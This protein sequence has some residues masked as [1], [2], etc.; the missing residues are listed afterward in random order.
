MAYGRKEIERRLSK[1]VQEQTPDILPQI[2]AARKTERGKVIDMTQALQNQKN[3]NKKKHTIRNLAIGAA[4]ALVLAIGGFAGYQYQFAVDTAVSIDVNP[5]IELEVN[6]QE[7]VLKAN[8]LNEDAK[9]LLDGMELEGTNLKTAV[10]AVIGSMV[11]NGYLTADANS[12]LLTVDNDD[13]ARREALQKELTEGV[14][15]SLKQLSLDGTVF[16]QSLQGNDELKALAAQY[17]ISEGK[18]RWI[19]MLTQADAS[20]KA[21]VLA[22]LSINDLALLAEARNL[23]GDYVGTADETGYIGTEKA[24]E[25]AV[26]KAGGGEV[27]SLEM[28]IDDGRMVYEGELVKDGVE[29]DFDI[30]ALEGTV[31]KW[32]KDGVAEITTAPDGLISQDKAKEIVLNKIPGATIT[33]LELDEDDGVWIYD[34]EAR[35]GQT[36]YDFEIK[37]AD[38]TILEWKS[39]SKNGTASSGNTTSSSSGSSSS[40]STGSSGTTTSKPSTSK[41]SSS[42]SAITKE[43]AKSLVLKKIPGATI[44]ELSVDYDD[45]RKVYEGEAYLNTSEYEFEIDASNGNFIK[46]KEEK[47][48]NTGNASSLISA[49]KAKSI[50]L[51]KVPGATVT[52]L[53]LDED[54]GGYYY[55][56]EARKGSMEYEFVIN[57]VNGSI[58]E[59]EA[60]RED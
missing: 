24:K 7:K 35:L 51:A 12:I 48:E 25:I 53:E 18:A 2:L 54:D 21:D 4:A 13:E 39:E 38:G 15:D 28:D 59:W 40:A 20:L 56:G 16:S 45:G 5:S 47:Q 52:D 60:D 55:E 23:S 30:D 9:T 6:R 26:T 17:G 31:I 57:A 32:E 3:N 37:A 1:A 34:G 58:V 46:W 11:Q 50:V 36:S 29:Y 10:N 41:P 33:K 27:T 22:E 49:E 43:Q 19:Q 42:T 44:V 8:P 14:N